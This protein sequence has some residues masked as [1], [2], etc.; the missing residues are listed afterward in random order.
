MKLGGLELMSD[1][2]KRILLYFEDSSMRGLYDRMD[3]WQHA[4]N[5]RLLSLSVQQDS[6]RYCCIALTN[7]TEVVIT[8]GSGKPISVLS[9]GDQRDILRLAVIAD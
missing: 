3:E 5:R 9:R 1:A 8:S 7:P 4:N 6:G 2:N